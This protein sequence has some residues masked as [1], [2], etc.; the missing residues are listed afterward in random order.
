MSETCPLCSAD[1]SDVFAEKT[2]YINQHSQ[3]TQQTRL[4]WQCRH[5]E[6][7]F[8]DHKQLPS[9]E[10]EKAL[11]DQHDND[12]N[13]A[14]YRR[15]LSRM[16]KPM[17]AKLKPAS[18]G[19]DFGCGPGPTL[20]TLFEAEGH[21]TANY[22]PMYDNNLELLNAHYDFICSTEVLEHIHWPLATLEKLWGLVLPGGIL[23]TM[24]KR[25]ID[26]DAFMRW[27]YTNDPTHVRFY[28]E[29]TFQWL[30]KR[31]NAVVEFPEKDVAIIIKPELRAPLK[32]SDK[33]C[34]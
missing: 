19:L 9:F 24:T 21:T 16:A 25:P 15:F 6:L 20:Y 27:H 32:V 13:D 28:S 31:W 10:E 1:N 33:R 18:K 29:A 8:V 30:A 7:I 34:P 3:K 26:Y 12:P 22:D 5:C 4:F 23:G 17:L 2:V 11:Y 14:G